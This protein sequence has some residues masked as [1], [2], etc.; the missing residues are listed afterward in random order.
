[1]F[2]KRDKRR[3]KFYDFDEHQWLV[4]AA[5]KIDSRIH[6]AVL[7]G[8]DAGIRRAE[9]IALEWSEWICGAG[10]SRSS[11]RVEE[12]SLVGWR[13]RQLGRRGRGRDR[14]WFEN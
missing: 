9:I 13:G 4:D 8:G 5:Q 12:R 14:R 10:S 11:V 6:V 3:A 1:V 2:R 7:L